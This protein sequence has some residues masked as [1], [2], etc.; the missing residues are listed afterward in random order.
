ML[1]SCLCPNYFFGTLALPSC[2]LWALGPPLQAAVDGGLAAS[3]PAPLL[4][5]TSLALQTHTHTHVSMWIS[6]SAWPFSWEAAGI[7]GCSDPHPIRFL[8]KCL[9]S[10]PQRLA[11]QA[12]S[13]PLCCPVP[14]ELR[15]LPLPWSACGQ[16]QASPL[17]CRPPALQQREW[18]PTIQ[19]GPLESR[20]ALVSG[21]PFSSS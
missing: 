16:R 19:A 14:G 7:V 11:G 13:L 15:A 1:I 17:P 3:P 6:G 10:S 2:D 12:V 18:T 9:Q 5:W 4:V 20:Q 21:S 8:V